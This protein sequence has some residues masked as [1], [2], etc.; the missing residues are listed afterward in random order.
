[1]YNELRDAR[2]ELFLPAD[3]FVACKKTFYWELT[4]EHSPFYTQCECIKR[5]QGIC[6]THDLDLDDMDTDDVVRT[7]HGIDSRIPN[8]ALERFYG[9]QMY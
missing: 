4:Y 3:P 7:L 1:M 5:V 8:M 2:P 6:D 9:I